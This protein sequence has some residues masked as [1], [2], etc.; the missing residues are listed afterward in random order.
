MSLPNIPK[1]KNY[2]IS[3][4]RALKALSSFGPDE[5]CKKTGGII[6]G[7]FLSFNFFKWDIKYDFSNKT[8]LLP[9]NL[10][11]P[12]TENLILHYIA[13]S[14]GEQP[15]DNWINFYQIKDATLYLPVFNKRTI[16]IINKAVKDFENWQKKCLALGGER[17]NFTSSS[18]AY[19][20]FAFPL[21]PIL[22]VYYEGDEDI[23]SELKF[24][25]DSS[26]VKNLS[27]EDTVVTSQFLSLQFF[28]V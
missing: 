9:E 17:Y 21:V 22:I 16:G 2:E 28:K 20:F 24:M 26:V 13:Y 7:S 1:Q 18:V 14:E 6:D 27:A 11:T 3:K 12:S 25:F 5:L 19:K 23:P 10:K 15:R 8:L 4:E